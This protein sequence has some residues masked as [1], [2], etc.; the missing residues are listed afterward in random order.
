MERRPEGAGDF[1]EQRLDILRMQGSKS[2]VL[3]GADLHRD[4]EVRTVIAPRPFTLLDRQRMLSDLVDVTVPAWLF[5]APEGGSPPDGRTRCRRCPTS[6]PSESPGPWALRT[7][8][9]AWF[10]L[11]GS[12]RRYGMIEFTFRNVDPTVP[13]LVTITADVNPYTAV[14]VSS[15]IDIQAS[16]AATRSFPMTGFGSHTFDL[17]VRPHIAASTFVGITLK[18]GIQYFGFKSVEY[19]ALT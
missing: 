1:D 6:M 17:V 11:G 8:P 19:Q 13:A 9:L 2:W 3:H 5:E 16:D 14:G 10:E 4:T 18:A 7:T 15:T 12:P